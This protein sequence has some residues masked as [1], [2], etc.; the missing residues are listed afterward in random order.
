MCYFKE[1]ETVSGISDIQQAIVRVLMS[2]EDTFNYQ[3]I[4]NEVRERLRELGVA[5]S[6]ADSYKVD[7]MIDNTLSQMM[8]KDSIV[9]IN[10]VYVPQKKPL[11][12]VRY[13]FS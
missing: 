3:N 13:A 12:K 11:R 8:A 6:I 10:N 2:K 4:L 9:C 1:M 5:E 7:N